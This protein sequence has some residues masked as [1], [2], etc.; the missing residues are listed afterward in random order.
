MNDITIEQCTIDGKNYEN[1]HAKMLKRYAH[2]ALVDI[3]NSQEFAE[4]DKNLL[5]S[6]IVV[7][8]R[9]IKEKNVVNRF[10]I[11]GSPLAYGRKKT[12]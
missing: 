5:N 4:V 10:K 8:Q 9:T 6:R 12:K 11:N 1:V 7:P 3:T 2:S